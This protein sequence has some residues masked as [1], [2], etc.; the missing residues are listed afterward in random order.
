MS[1]QA[2]HVAVNNV[3]LSETV[4]WKYLVMNFMKER[5]TALTGSKHSYASSG[6]HVKLQELRKLVLQVLL[7]SFENK[8]GLLTMT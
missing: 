1:A 8:T 6:S 3:W 4:N 2:G 5:A 7:A